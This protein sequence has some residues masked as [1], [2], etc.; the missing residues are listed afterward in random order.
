MNPSVAS[1]PESTAEEVA[2][3]RSTSSD[4]RLRDRVIVA[5]ARVAT[6]TFFPSIEVIGP[7]PPPGPT[8]LAA[9]HLYGFVDPVMLIARLGH[10]PRFLAKA[11]LWTNPA[12]RIPLNFAGV[13]AVHR[14]ADGST[15]GNAAMFADAIAALAHHD[16]VAVFA[17]GTTHDDPTIRPVRT[18]IARIA[19]QAAGNGIEGIQV[20]PI[21]ITYDDKVALRGRVLVHYGEPIR[22]P[23]DPSLLGDDGA[24]D[25]AKTREFTDHLQTRI[26]ALTP[27]FDSTE[28]ALA[29]TTAAQITR[30][31]TTPGRAEAKVAMAPVAADAR[32]LSKV[33]PA[34]RGA[35]VDL[36]ARYEML[37]GY[38]GLDDATVHA[39]VNLPSLLRRILVLTAVIVVLSPFAVAGL[40]ANLVPVLL[41]LVA[42]LVPQAPVSKGTIRVLVGVVTFPLTWLVLALADAG[43]G[44][45]GNLARTVTLPANTLLGPLAHDRAGWVAALVV[46]IA[47]PLMGIFA[48]IVVGRARSLL[49]AVLRWR[50]YVDRRGQLDAVRARRDDVVTMTRSLL[51]EPR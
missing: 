38:I 29:L 17:E 34:R 42:G 10:L 49:A 25:H 21:G 13:I 32:E 44:P 35:L 46:L 2:S 28:E 37:R 14:A 23:P 31:T 7:P 39:G 22:V 8:I 24:A 27:H 40:F 19:L 20:V 18:G 11:T 30:R 45:L 4:K 43:T 48:V 15:E 12:A 36:V 41:V 16:T 3:P 51:T 6:R 47:V 33:D 50:T 5:A 9:S 1:P 26:E